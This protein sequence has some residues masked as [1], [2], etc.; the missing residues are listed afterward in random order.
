VG[1]G[2]VGEVDVG[3]ANAAVVP[4]LSGDEI[5]CCDGGVEDEPDLGCLVRRVLRHDVRPME[6]N[7]T[8]FERQKVVRH[9]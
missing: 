2:R 7:V 9:R 1:C 6:C 4:H 5:D 8:L 3:S